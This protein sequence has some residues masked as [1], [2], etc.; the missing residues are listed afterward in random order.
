MAAQ[1]HKTEGV[2]APEGKRR[3]GEGLA[4]LLSQLGFTSMRRYRD[5]LAPLGLEPRHVGL[6]N[7]VAR[8]QGQTQQALGEKL[9]IPP[10]R[11]VAIVDELE[12]AGI[13]ERRPNPTDRRARA[14]HL[15]PHGERLLDD[16]MRLSAGHEQW[17]TGG[18]EPAERDQ[19]I[20]LLRRLVE[21]RGL[22]PGVHPGLGDPPR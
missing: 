19:L 3:P 12:G 6:L 20:A 18:L 7:A 21:A 1:P 13:L 11:M 2:G 14:V 10:S 8:A 17:L 15:T 4:F 22:A 5:S 9:G 16:A